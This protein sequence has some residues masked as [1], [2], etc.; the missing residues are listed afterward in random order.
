MLTY[1]NDDFEGGATEFVDAADFRP[2]T[3]VQPRANRT[4]VFD[5]E[6]FHRGNAVLQGVKRWIGTELVCHRL[7]SCIL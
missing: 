2:T 6:L 5:I 1:L 4:L 7:Y 3:I